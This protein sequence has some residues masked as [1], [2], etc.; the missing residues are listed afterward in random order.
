MTEKKPIPV[1][2][3]DGLIKADVGSWAE[4]KYR[5]L[6]NYDTLFSSGMKK[7]WDQRVYVDLFSGSGVSKLKDSK[8]LFYGS[9]MLA[10][11]V[12]NPFDK[13]VFCDDDPERIDALRIRSKNSSPD[14]NALFIIGNCNEKA[15][16]VLRALP[17]DEKTLTLCVVD[18]YNLDGI[19]FE[20]FKLLAQRRTDFFVLL[21]D[22]DATMNRS[23]YIEPSSERISKV[24]GDKEWR[25]KWRAEERQ[26]VGF[27]KFV[28]K[29]FSTRMTSI[30][31]LPTPDMKP[32]RNNKN[33]VIYH[34]AL[35]SKHET[36]HKFWDE[37]NRYGSDQRP[38]DF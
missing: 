1:P 10:I 28:F 6:W 13:Y 4:E 27:T 23:Q 36:A 15:S 12:P 11:K 18:P 32:I 37:A 17:K 3:D 31:Y 21:M 22:M 7:K 29:A 25:E 35:F 19:R 14:A 8:H 9:P 34:L 38:L 24:L 30:G 16:E 33:S 2:Q 26:G 20:T 5:L